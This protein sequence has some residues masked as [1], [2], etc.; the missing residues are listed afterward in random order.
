MVIAHVFNLATFII[1]S[2]KGL[3]LAC[4]AEASF[5]QLFSEYPRQAGIEQKSSTYVMGIVGNCRPQHWRL[6]IF[7]V[8]YTLHKSYG[9]CS[10]WWT[11]ST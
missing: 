8:V 3:D 4:Q 6:C 10:C 7:S 11:A 5:R 9:S 2:V 1:D